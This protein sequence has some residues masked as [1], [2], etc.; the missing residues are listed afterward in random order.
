MKRLALSLFA[1]LLFASVSLAQQSDADAPASKADIER[2]LDAMHSRTMMKNMM[3]TMT[4]QMHKMVHEQMEKQSNLP[5]DFEAK[6]DKITDDMF[7][8]FPVDELIDVMIPVYQKHLTKGDIDALVAF[9]SS[10][11]G[12][13][14]IKEMPAITSESMQAASGIIQKMS[15]NAMQRVQD[16][17][18]QAQ[19]ADETKPDDGKKPKQT[20]PTSN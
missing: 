18:A 14:F 12:Q 15:A 11:A 16:E 13:K 4:I 17:I 20:A 1:V 8:N 19:K 5:P 10:P 2:Y 6:M 3:G 9:Y 7:N